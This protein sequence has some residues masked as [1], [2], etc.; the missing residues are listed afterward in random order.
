MA[1]E[2]R[3]RGQV[4]KE[5]AIFDSQLAQAMTAQSSTALRQRIDNVN[6]AYMRIHNALLELLRLQR[7]GRN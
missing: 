5:K 7:L 1:S 6:S 3:L 4:K 2:E